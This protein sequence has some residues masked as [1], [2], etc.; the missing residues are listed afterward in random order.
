MRALKPHRVGRLVLVE[1][2]RAPRQCGGSAERGAV[3]GRLGAFVEVSVAGV[4]KKMV[5]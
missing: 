1:K 4:V 2:A 3:L 5:Q